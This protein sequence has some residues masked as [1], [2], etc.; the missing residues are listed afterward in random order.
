MQTL[1]VPTADL[2]GLNQQSW[3]RLPGGAGSDGRGRER[4]PVREAGCS[5]PR[6]LA[7]SPPLHILHEDADCLA[8]VKPAGQFTQ[9]TWAPP[10]E[11]TL[12]AGDPAPSRPGRSGRGLPGHRAPAGP[13]DVG[14]AD[15][16][17]D[18]AGGPPALAPVRAPARRQGILGAGRCRSWAPAERRRSAASGARGDETW[19]DWLTRTGQ[20]GLA[21]V[22]PP[23][24]PGRGR[25]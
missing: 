21:R 6:F 13:A 12:E 16:G 19:S 2:P 23:G 11:L 4:D 15:L 9:G 10:G 18:A 3:V 25:R 17:Q 8:V 5:T 14:S 7:M 22:V 20:T 1:R 24:T